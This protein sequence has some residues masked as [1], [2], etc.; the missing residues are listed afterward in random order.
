MPRTSSKKSE[1]SKDLK[2]NKN[3]DRKPSSD[4][5]D[6]V[7]SIIN[8]DQKPQTDSSKKPEEET[9]KEESEIKPVSNKPRK[10]WGLMIVVISV[11]V[12]IIVGLTL[13]GIGIYSKGWSSPFIDSVTKVIPFPV[14]KVD[15]KYI[16]YTDY[17]QE[18][19]TLDHYYNAQAEEFPEYFELP[20]SSI[21]QKMVLSRMFEEYIVDQLAEQ[22]NITVSQEE[23]DA[24]FQ[25]I[26]DQAT[27]EKE[28]IDTLSNLY[29]WSP[30]QFKEKV[31]G[32]Y[33]VRTK[34]QE[35]LS[36]V[37]DLN[38]E[39]R[40]EAE[41]VLALVQAG[42]QTFEELA[43]EYS[44][45]GSA[46]VGGDLGFFGS[47]DMVPSFEE[48]AFAL[49]I[50]E[51]SGIVS[52]PFGFHIIKL[53]ERIP[54]DEEAGTGEVVRARHILIRGA[55]VESLIQEFAEQVNVSIYLSGLFWESSCARVLLDGETCETD[56]L[57]SFIPS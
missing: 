35:A 39:Q 53:E 8:E 43:Q 51:V 27:S 55:T 52:S 56:S 42:E 40:A 3:N 45:D 15:S 34:L 5:R 25:L 28:V 14:A 44:E 12:V 31:L 50:G 33:Q 48:A 38:S 29:D 2:P 22:Y 1:K 26:I 20:E 17:T 46:E 9:H 37:A 13:V 19:L 57:Q 32:P 36:S 18:Y 10:K 21:L 7:L 23:V 49:E 4:S 6:E 11:L 24:E 30:A 47:G 41:K 16:S 54:A